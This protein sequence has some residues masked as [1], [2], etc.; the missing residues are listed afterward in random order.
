VK[1][2]GVLLSGSS[3]KDRID[4]REVVLEYLPT[5]EMIVDFMTKPLQGE[6]SP[7]MRTLLMNFLSK[8]SVELMLFITSSAG[9]CAA[10]LC[11]IESSII[12]V[13]CW[14]RQVSAGLIH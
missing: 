11:F 9:V 5:G 12:Q 2:R 8:L 14:S 13:L 10:N 3:C 1:I 7:K 4:I 6:L